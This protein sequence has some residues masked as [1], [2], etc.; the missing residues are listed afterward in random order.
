MKHLLYEEKY[1]IE[2]ARAKL[3]QLRRSGRLPEIT[4]RAMTHD[5]AALVRHELEELLEILTPNRA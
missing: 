4:S 1:T 2:G 3:D 5:T